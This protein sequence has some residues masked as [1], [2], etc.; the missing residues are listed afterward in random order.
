MNP[1]N[2]IDNN[3]CD[4]HHLCQVTAACTFAES[5]YYKLQQE[6]QDVQ[7][8]KGDTARLV[9]RLSLYWTPGKVVHYYPIDL[10]IV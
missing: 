5:S 2:P 10:H 1:F 8:G 6:V 9:D 7:A 3:Y 4:Q